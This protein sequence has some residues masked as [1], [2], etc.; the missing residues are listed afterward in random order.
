MCGRHYSGVR[1][2]L[3]LSAMWA[4]TLIELLV[5]IAIIGILAAMLLPAL[6]SAKS[7]AQG[8]LCLNS[9]KQMMMA[10][11]MYVSDYHDYFPPNPDDGNTIPGHN[12]A[13]GQAGIGQPDEFNSDVLKDPD[14]SLLISYL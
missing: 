12:W 7:K 14:R 9:G 8:S 11:L 6:S 13:G 10:M 1:I 4:F 2:R 5:V 3:K